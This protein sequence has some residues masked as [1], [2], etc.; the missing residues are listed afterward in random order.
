MYM[1]DVYRGAG[2]AGVPRGTV[3][4]LRVFEYNYRYRHMASH[5]LI[6]PDGLWEPHRI[7]GTVPVEEDGSAYFR[8]LAMTPLAVQPLDEKGTRKANLL[9]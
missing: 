2:L 5:N 4:R 1:S 8:V 6:G 7:W 3:K 9:V